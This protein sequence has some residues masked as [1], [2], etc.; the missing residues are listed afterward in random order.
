MPTKRT[1]IHRNRKARITPEVLAAYKHGDVLTL[2]R[3]LGLKPCEASPLPYK[4]SALGVDQDT[5]P[6]WLDSHGLADWRQA[7]DLQLE[8]EKALR[9]E[10]SDE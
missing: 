9:E 4:L 1:P 3:L 6:E 8:I 10:E 5:P 2:H 7:Q